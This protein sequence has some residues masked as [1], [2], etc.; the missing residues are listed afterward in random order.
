MRSTRGIN[1]IVILILS[2]VVIFV[3]TSIFRVLPGRITRG[4][5]VMHF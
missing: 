3:T 2:A 4:I 1:V 5:S